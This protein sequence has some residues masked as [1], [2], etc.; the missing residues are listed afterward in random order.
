MMIAYHFPFA[1]HNFTSIY[2]WSRIGVEERFSGRVGGHGAQIAIGIA[3]ILRSV[4]ILDSQAVFKYSKFHAGPR[5][6]LQTRSHLH[7]Y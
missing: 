7:T 3:F 1:L 4:L 6:R 5:Y 2:G